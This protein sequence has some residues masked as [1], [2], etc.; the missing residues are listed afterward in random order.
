MEVDHIY[1]CT[2]YK[3]PVGDL[4]KEFGLIEGTS[5]IHPGQGTANRRFFFHNFMLELLWI[6]NLKE[7]KSDL[8]KPMRHF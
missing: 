2:D 3:A 8:T 5:N 7:V 1:I 6:E 4:L